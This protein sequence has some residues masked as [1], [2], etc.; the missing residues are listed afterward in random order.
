MMM[1][2]YGDFSLNEFRDA[3]ADS[4]PT[5]GGG[6]AAAV[7]LSQAAA[8]TKMVTSLTLGKE[9]WES[10]WAAA[11]LALDVTEKLFLEAMN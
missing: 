3:L 11:E 5:P 10:G 9:R 7:A 8:L 4:A 2:E 6:S 1:P